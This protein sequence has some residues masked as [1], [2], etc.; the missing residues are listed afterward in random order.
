MEWGEAPAFPVRKMLC[1]FFLNG[2]PY[3]CFQAPNFAICLHIFS[4]NKVCNDWHE[5]QNSPIDQIFD[6]PH[7]FDN[8]IC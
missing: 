1:N 5:T 6:I 3:F 2:L 7:L 8:P 4:K